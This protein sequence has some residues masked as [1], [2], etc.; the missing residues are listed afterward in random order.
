MKNVIIQSLL[1][2]MNLVVSKFD[3]F[4]VSHQIV[5]NEFE[6]NFFYDK[7]IIFYK[8]NKIICEDKELYINKLDKLNWLELSNIIEHIKKEFK[9][10]IK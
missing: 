6:L 10:R 2:I 9:T 3:K 5:F 8:G 1:L 7:S 4:S